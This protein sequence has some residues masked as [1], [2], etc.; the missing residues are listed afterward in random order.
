MNQ[1]RNY[2]IETS[3]NEETMRRFEKRFETFHL[4]YKRGHEVKTKDSITGEWFVRGTQ[5]NHLAFINEILNDTEILRFEYWGSVAESKCGSAPLR[6]NHLAS[7]TSPEQRR[8]SSIQSN[9]SDNLTLFHHPPKVFFEDNFPPFNGSFR[10]IWDLFQSYFLAG[11]LLAGCCGQQAARE[12]PASKQQ[13]CSNKYSFCDH[14]S[15]NAWAL[16]NRSLRLKSASGHRNLTFYQP[17]TTKGQFGW[18]STP[19][20]FYAW[21]QFNIISITYHGK[22]Q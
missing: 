3:Y 13:G 2:R 7:L 19:I 12:G 15:V 5:K 6:G 10:A 18:F 14:L 20:Y 1:M 22:D 11:L 8:D 21:Y 4:K 17:D 9:N 16:A